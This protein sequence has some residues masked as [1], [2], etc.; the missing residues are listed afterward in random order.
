M[1]KYGFHPPPIIHTHCESICLE[2]CQKSQLPNC[3]N[4]ETGPGDKWYN[5]FKKQNSLTNKKSDN[6]DCGI[7]RVANITVY[8]QQFTLLEKISNDL[9]LT[10]KPDRLKVVNPQ[11]IL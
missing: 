8:E 6:I 11:H 7:S 1:A 10:M 3:F 9:E 5:K 4:A 2:F